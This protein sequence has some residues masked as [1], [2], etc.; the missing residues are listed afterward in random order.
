VLSLL[1]VYQMIAQLFISVI[2]LIVDWSTWSQAL[3]LS[4]YAA[5]IYL[6]NVCCAE[7]FC[8]FCVLQRKCIKCVLCRTLQ[9]ESLADFSKMVLDFKKVVPG[10]VTKHTEFVNRKC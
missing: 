3:S 2:Y 6:L 8:A 7:R 10:L 5:L 1:V 9:R 4:L